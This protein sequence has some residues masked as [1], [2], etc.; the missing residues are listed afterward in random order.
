MKR[1]CLYIAL[2]WQAFT[3]Y[4]QQVDY[5][6]QSISDSLK[7]DAHSIVREFTTLVDIHSME[8]GEATFRKV[9]VLP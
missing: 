9:V 7:Q 1:L 5:S 3:V 4:G 6:L 8:E 2:L